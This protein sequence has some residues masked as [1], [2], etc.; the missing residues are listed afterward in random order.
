M[1]A[2]LPLLKGNNSGQPQDETWLW[3]KIKKTQIN[4]N[5][6]Q[7]LVCTFAVSFVDEDIYDFYHVRWHVLRSVITV[8]KMTFLSNPC[9]LST[10]NGMCCI[11]GWTLMM[12]SGLYS[13]KPASTSLYFKNLPKVKELENMK[14]TKIQEFK[15]HHI[16]QTKLNGNENKHK[17]SA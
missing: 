14:K 11:R 8:A 10:H 1:L 3:N 17:F 5:L 4:S 9:H 7:N 13:I 15:R 6:N 16:I 12:I 2:L